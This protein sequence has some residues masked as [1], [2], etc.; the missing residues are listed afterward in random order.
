MIGVVT[1]LAF[2]PA[3]YGSWKTRYRNTTTA[4]AFTPTFFF[5]F[6]TTTGQIFRNKTRR[7]LPAAGAEPKSRVILNLTLNGW[8]GVWTG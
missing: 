5:T 4:T 6:L 3:M 8:D 7:W 2:L 1:V